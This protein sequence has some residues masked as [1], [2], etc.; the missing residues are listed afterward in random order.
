MK[1]SLLTLLMLSLVLTSFSQK[2]KPKAQYG[3]E[4][5][6]S[7]TWFANGDQAYRGIEYATTGVTAGVYMQQYLDHQV[8]LEIKAIYAS[9]GAKN[10]EEDKRVFRQHNVVLPVTVG[11][12]F[13]TLSVS[14]GGYVSQLITVQNRDFY[15]PGPNFKWA[16]ANWN[17]YHTTDY[18]VTLGGNIDLYGAN[19]DVQWFT[20]L[21]NVR[22]KYSDKDMKM[23]DCNNRGIRVSLQVPLRPLE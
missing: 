1:Q 12:D 16:V 11:V 6:V 18:G 19:I 13:G 9:G 21:R 8:Y 5:G 2:K 10:P 4:G 3:I 17:W 20:G 22:N 15:T 7:T 14:A 23:Y